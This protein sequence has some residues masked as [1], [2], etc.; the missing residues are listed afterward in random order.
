MQHIIG[1]QTHKRSL[2]KTIRNH[3]TSQKKINQITPTKETWKE[4]KIDKRNPTQQ[5]QISHQ[6]PEKTHKRVK[7]QR[8]LNL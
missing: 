8:N 1:T 6:E 4:K 7:K 5:D 2:D 3:I